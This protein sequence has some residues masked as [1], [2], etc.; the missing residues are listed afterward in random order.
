MKLQT[1][2]SQDAEHLFLVIGEENIVI[3]MNLDQANQ[4]MGLIFDLIKEAK[5]QKSF[6]DLERDNAV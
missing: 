2:I 5:A 4:L 3:D 6:L 1:A